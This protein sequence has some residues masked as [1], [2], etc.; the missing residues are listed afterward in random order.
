MTGTLSSK[1]RIVSGSL[2]SKTLI[3]DVLM[4]RFMLLQRHNRRRSIGPSTRPVPRD[5][6]QE[7]LPLPALHRVPEPVG[8]AE[9]VHSII[10]CA[11][12]PRQ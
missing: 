1:L 2:I 9:P 7:L 10:P 6:C 8:E 11:V 5:F 3:E 4:C 12:A